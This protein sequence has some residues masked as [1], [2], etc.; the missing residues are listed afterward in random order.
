LTS[1][2]SAPA[3]GYRA[4]VLA[5]LR[6]LRVAIIEQGQWGTC[7]NRGC[8]PKTAW[9]HGAR[10][11]AASRG[12]AERGIAGALTGDLAQAWRHQRAVVTQVQTSYMDYLKR[13]G[14]SRYTGSARFVRADL[15]SVG[16]QRLT[17]PHTIIATVRHPIFPDCRA[18]SA[19]TPMTCST[20]GPRGDVL[21][22][23]GRA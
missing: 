7:L 17:A 9:Y 4:A 8:V 16:E 10:V 6:G 2:S 3:G 23:S 18:R 5:A 12:F 15:V 14:V 11:I 20:P 1:S 22:S 19:L 21:R 13:L